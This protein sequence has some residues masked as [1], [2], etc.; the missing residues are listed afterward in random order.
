MAALPT[1]A[2]LSKP[3]ITELVDWCRR[4]GV[5]RNER[6]T[7]VGNPFEVVDNIDWER[8]FETITLGYRTAQQRL[9]EH[10]SLRCQASLLTVELMPY[11]YTKRSCIVPNDV[12]RDP[13]HMEWQ[14][15]R[16]FG[17]MITWDGRGYSLSNEA[18]DLLT[19]RGEPADEQ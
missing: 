16:K 14:R 8:D 15:L 2:G 10:A 5:R 4:F 1:N 17:E 6:L 19:R 9:D 7:P 18:F 13:K 3:E 12:F 11:K